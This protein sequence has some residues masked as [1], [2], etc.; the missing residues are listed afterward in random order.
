M[1][2]TH[3][4]TDIPA[5]NEYPKLVRDKIPELIRKDGKVPLTQTL[6]DEDILQYLLTKL[7]EESS[8]LA[9]AKT[10]EHQKEELADVYEV[11]EALL[12]ALSI[13]DADIK[14]VQASKKQ[15]R[16]GFEDRVLL[17]SKPK[18]S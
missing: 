10:L 15:E 12:A 2:Y 11:I 6:G 1:D 17:V 13:S 8:E 5:E 16:G 4:E 3:T 9:A 14:K 18:Q 7:I